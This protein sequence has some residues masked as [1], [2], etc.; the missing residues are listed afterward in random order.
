MAQETYE[1]DNG[2]TVGPYPVG[3]EGTGN[4]RRV[5]DLFYSTPSATAWAG[6]REVAQAD[7]K[8]GSVNLLK[9][10]SVSSR[11][12]SET[13]DIGAI[14][15]S[16]YVL[17]CGSVDFA[18]DEFLSANSKFGNRD[19][20]LSALEMMGREPVPVGLS[21]IEFAN[22]EI[23]TITEKESTQYTLVLTLV[24]ITAALIC[25]IVVIVRRK[26]R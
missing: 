25:G 16:S 1:D 15:D 6:D 19:L 8:N 10:M 2:K 3:R 23:Q 17:L 21:Y 14:T 9:L 20:L 22:Y 18:S 24:P 26:N 4:F 7:D 12:E 11:M 13:E 5:Y